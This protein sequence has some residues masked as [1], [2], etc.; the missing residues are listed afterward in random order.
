MRITEH[1]KNA[2]IDAVKNADPTRYL[3][4]AAKCV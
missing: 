3:G 1:E 4:E 2:I